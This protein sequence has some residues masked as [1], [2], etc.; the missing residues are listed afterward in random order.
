[1]KVFI[2]GV[3]GGVG[4]ALARQLVKAGH[5]VWGVARREELLKKMQSELGTDKF[6]FTRCDVSN[7]NDVER[8]VKTMKAANFLPEIVVLNAAVFFH[9][10]GFSYQHNLFKQGMAI[11]VFGALIWVD[12]FMPDF[13]KRGS[14]SFIAVSSVSAYLPHSNDIFHSASKAALSMAFRSLQ[15]NY[16]ETNINFSVINFGPI[17]TSLS[18]QWA[19]SAGRPKYFFVLTPEKAAD[20]ISEVIE[21]KN[22]KTIYWKPFPI[23]WLWRL[24][25]FFPDNLFSLLSKYLKS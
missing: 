1:M 10:A 3:S 19:D 18:P 15:L 23:S 22:K 17:A 24:V 25:S 13:L 20:C 2:T 21:D 12:K 5:A 9:N 11:N 14:G 8:V 4:E 16:H 7:E 6:L